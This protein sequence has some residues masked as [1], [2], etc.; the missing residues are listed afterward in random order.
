MIILKL[1]LIF[2][3][4]FFFIKLIIKNASKLN[5][6]DIP[7]ER[8]YHT[9]ITPR[10]AGIGFGFAFFVSVILFEFSLFFEHWLIFLAIF[11][12]FVIG[13]LDDHK[14]T[15][16]K[17]KI[18]VIFLASLLLYFDGV[19]IES[20]GSFFGFEIPLGY[21]AFPLS[22][23]FLIGF[24][25]ALNLID[26]LDGLSASISTFLYIGYI[27]Q[28]DLVITICLFTIVSLFAFLVFNW[29]PASIFMGDSG[30]LFL[31][32]VIATVA[33]MSLQY[34]DPVILLYLLSVP[35]IDTFV[36]MTR[37]IKKK[38]SPFSADKTHIHHILLNFFAKK[39]KRTVFF[40][41]LVQAIFSLGGLMLALSSKEIGEGIGSTVL[42]LLFIGIV[43]LSYMIF[44][45]MKR[46]QKLIEKL[47]HRRK[48][49]LK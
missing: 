41:V 30:S 6:S 10:G 45:G 39:V 9:K 42:L 33:L 4:S 2:F 38:K 14:N 27:N 19:H 20:L 23:I 7:N 36:V 37:R 3:L 15:S 18:L 24:T 22:L 46:R 49:A 31:G 28:N 1:T 35:T 47:A 5:L 17:Q 32:F 25:N 34:I 8:S 44:T 16:P 13:I 43:I 40:L 11:L 12:V 48:R 26:G 29:N 21:I